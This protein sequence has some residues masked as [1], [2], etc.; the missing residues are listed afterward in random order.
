MQALMAGSSTVGAGGL[1]ALLGGGAAGG[2]GGLGALSGLLGGGA[3][4]G[5][6]G[7]GL[8]ALL[9][10]GAGAGN[11]GGL[12]ALLG[13]G[14]VE[15]GP[16]PLLALL[17]GAG[18][19]AMESA[20]AQT[21]P[22]GELNALLIDLLQQREALPEGPIWDYI[23][24]ARGGEI[25][26]FDFDGTLHTHD[27]PSHIGEPRWDTLQRLAEYARKGYT[28]IITTSRDKEHNYEI[29]NFLEHIGIAQSVA[30][31]FNTKS[32]GLF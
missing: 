15:G 28:V 25:V 29:W 30:R 12:A 3:G 5:G 27:T 24:A 6:A 20:T 1:A 32:K 19:A 16:N 10:G 14:G 4:G 8:S 21:N 17:G 18:S 7:G 13:G 31:I 2:Q 26:S 23:P 11:A 9:A 22:N